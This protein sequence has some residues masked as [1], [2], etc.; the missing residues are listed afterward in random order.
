MIA[1]IYK[2]EKASVVV[3]VTAVP[4]TAAA[5][6]TFTGRKKKM[7]IEDQTL[8]EQSEYFSVNAA[9]ATCLG[10]CDDD[11]E[12]ATYPYGPGAGDFHEY[13]EQTSIDPQTMANH[14]SFV[15]DRANS[16]GGAATS[17][18]ATV[19][20]FPDAPEGSSA[21]DWIGLRRPQNVP[22]GDPTQIS[23]TIR[24]SDFT[25]KSTISWSH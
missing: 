10:K 21:I 12:F 7:S 22:V 24:M 13:L 20:A 6:E 11:G 19:S 25:D 4:T 5:A 2:K 18:G 3:P 9:D 23:D 16:V 17:T 15:A 14:N 1:Y 8:R